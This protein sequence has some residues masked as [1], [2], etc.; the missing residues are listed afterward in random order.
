MTQRIPKNV[1]AKLKQARAAATLENAKFGFSTDTVIPSELGD[2]QDRQPVT[3]DAFIKDKVR[4]HHETWIVETIDEVLN[5]AEG[6]VDASD[7][8][9]DH[10]YL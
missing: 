9:T 3:V 5:W 2:K 1:I 10:R 6:K 7:L 8:K 4:P